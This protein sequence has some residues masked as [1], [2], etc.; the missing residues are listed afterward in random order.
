MGKDEPHRPDDVGRRRPQHLALGERVAHEFEGVM[1]EVAQAAVDELG[2]GRRGRRGEV[3]LLDQQDFQA[4]AG[5][6]ARNPGP[7]DAA[8]DDDEIVAH[9]WLR[10]L[11]DRSRS[12]TSTNPS[13]PPPFVK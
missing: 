6:V 5:R 13:P 2:R 4:P 11:A 9:V 12:A 1:L 8:A 10:F 7:V 3:V